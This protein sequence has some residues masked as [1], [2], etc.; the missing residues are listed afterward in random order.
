MWSRNG[1]LYLLQ[2]RDF[3]HG[4]HRVQRERR[5]GTEWRRCLHEQAIL[6][7]SS[8]DGRAQLN[9][10][11][12]YVQNLLRLPTL[13]HQA[14]IS[15]LRCGHTFLFKSSHE[16]ATNSPRWQQNTAPHPSNTVS[17]E[18][19][20]NSELQLWALIC[21]VTRALCYQMLCL[22]TSRSVLC[23]KN[24]VVS[25]FLVQ[26]QSLVARTNLLRH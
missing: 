15:Q 18:R 10:G 11:V 4:L 13:I 6:Q 1:R 14:L 25:G 17:R 7:V 8:R 9:S 23:P 16:S 24:S 22:S 12:T 20:V 19:D 3:Q 2:S 5:T 26:N 21:I